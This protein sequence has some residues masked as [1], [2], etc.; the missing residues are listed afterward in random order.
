MWETYFPTIVCYRDL[1]D[2]REINARLLPRIA[3]LRE[4]DAAGIVRSNVAQVGAWH[5]D[6]NV[7]TLPE[8]AQLTTAIIASAQQIF[9]EL[10]YDPNYGPSVDN[11]WVNVSP[12]YA[13]NRSHTHPN[14]LWSGVYY[15]QAPEGA[16]RIHFADPRAEAVVMT[17]RY[18]PDRKRRREMWTEVYYQP[19]EG[20]LIL[21][22]SWLRHEVEPNLS[23]AEGAEGDRISISFNIRQIWRGVQEPAGTAA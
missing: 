6:L 11:M 21:F 23:A 18:V 15:V 17:P 16:G 12:R 2:G 19:I 13:Y 20:R 14:T 1:P 8:F 7:H 4:E 5:S 9:D 3:R 10:G 22:P